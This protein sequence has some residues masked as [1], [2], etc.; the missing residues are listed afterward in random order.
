M[1]KLGKDLISALKEAKKK[2]L[3]TLQVS[4]GVGKIHKKIKGET[5]WQ[6]VKALKEKKLIAAAKSD[7]DAKPLTL[8]QLKK[9]KRVNSVGEVNVKGAR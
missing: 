4:P 8:A 5:N 1:S 2:G 7:P 9:F 6:K 3:V